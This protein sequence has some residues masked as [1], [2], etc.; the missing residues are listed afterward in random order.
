MGRFLDDDGGQPSQ[1]TS[2]DTEQQHELLVGQMAFP[3]CVETSNPF[4]E[5]LF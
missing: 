5:L 4:A 2:W 1:K 3:P